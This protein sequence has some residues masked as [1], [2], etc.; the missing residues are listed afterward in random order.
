MRVFEL[1]HQMWL[2]ASSWTMP[3]A[4]VVKLKWSTCVQPTI[5]VATDT[6]NLNS[7]MHAKS[8]SLMHVGIVSR[9]H[10]DYRLVN[11][12]Y[13]TASMSLPSV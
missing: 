12:S 10:S 3:A 8:N 13:V 9:S 5:I 6:L 2:L 1:Q 11:T 7:L 4:S